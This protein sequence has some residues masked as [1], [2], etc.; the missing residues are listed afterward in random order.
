MHNL[1]FLLL[2]GVASSASAQGSM[3]SDPSQPS[4]AEPDLEYRS[5]F[6]DYRAFKEDRLAPWRDANEE[7]GRLGGKGGHADHGKP[8]A[9]NP[10]AGE[11]PASSAK[12]VP[13]ARTGRHGG[14]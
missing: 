2:A 13:E 7:V 8:P 1:L 4:A 3:R 11:S 10:P 6:K 12:P 14:H 5:A 9:T